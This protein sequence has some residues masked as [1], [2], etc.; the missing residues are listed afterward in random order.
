MPVAG[1]VSGGATVNGH[2]DRS[3]TAQDFQIH[4][5]KMS[6]NLTEPTQAK[7]DLEWETNI[8][9]VKGLF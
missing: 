7:Y 1:N 2:L 9:R 3:G 8:E 6:L 4:K 5:K